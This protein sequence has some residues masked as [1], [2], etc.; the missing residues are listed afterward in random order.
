MPISETTMDLIEAQRATIKALELSCK[1]T[2]N[3][4][5][6]AEKQVYKLQTEIS[7]LSELL[8]YQDGIIENLKNESKS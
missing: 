6:S 5:D 3:R 1:N 7:R 8:H 4:A 2:I